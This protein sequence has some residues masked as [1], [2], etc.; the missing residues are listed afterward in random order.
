MVAAFALAAGAL[1]G[2][3]DATDSSGA[4]A[5]H[6][7]ASDPGTAPTWWED[8][9]PIVYAECV[10][11]HQEGG[12]APVALIEYEDARQLSGLMA[13]EVEAR[14]M[15][16]WPA[17]NSGTC[18]TFVDARWLS[19][20]QID[21]IVAWT[22]A[23]APEGDPANRPELPGDP[24]GL[25]E[26]TTTLDTMVDYTPDGDLDDEYR[27]FIVDPQITEDMYLT[28]Y[29]VKPGDSRVVHHVILYAFADEASEQE[30]QGLDNAEA[31][32]GYTCF[33]GP[34]VDGAT[35]AGGWAP[36]TPP[37]VYPEG[38]GIPLR[39]NR[40]AVMQIH[41]NTLNGVWSDRTK[42][43]LT[44][45]ASVERQALITPI[46]DGS[47]AL[48][49]QQ[50]YVETSATMTNPAPVPLLV[51]GMYP[52]MHQLGT[53]INVSVVQDAG[54]TCM[55]DVPEWDFNWQQFYLYEEPL[56]IMPGDQLRITCGYSTLD[57][58][59]TVYWGDGTQDEMCLN[60]LYVTTM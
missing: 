7:G 43:D 41:Y 57:Q 50:D 59:K 37:T 16:P 5:A 18:N 45:A 28:A 39:A 19:Q 51:H 38:T 53:N 31:G 36:G 6:Q 25:A 34:G 42:M 30:A 12:I 3:G 55:I 40:K 52:H 9:A 21:T 58:D 46:V 49:P 10:S 13:S 35:F 11:C 14:R 22:K 56:V 2:C 60:F 1:H 26:V 29:E 47:L 54:E 32:P 17:G 48:P 27:C 4:G 44:L 15:P 24:P 23:G 33:G 20:D 8:V